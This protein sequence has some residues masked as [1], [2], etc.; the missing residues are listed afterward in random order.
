MAPALYVSKSAQLITD[1]PLP[2]RPDTVTRV[3]NLSAKTEELITRHPI[4]SPWR[5]WDGAYNVTKHPLPEEKLRVAKHVYQT[6]I[7]K[8]L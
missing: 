5:L 2:A 3:Y 6:A 4:A 7:S 8:G 1:G